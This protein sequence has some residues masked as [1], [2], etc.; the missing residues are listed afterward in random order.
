MWTTL[1]NPDLDTEVNIYQ[2][3]FE[4]IIKSQNF[5]INACCIDTNNV[6]QKHN[7]FQQKF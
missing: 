6:D 3:Y 2:E 1:G 7:S 5:Y 4:V